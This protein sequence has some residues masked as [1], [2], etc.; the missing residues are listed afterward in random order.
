MPLENLDAR[1]LKRRLDRG[2]PITLLD[3][4]EPFERQLCAIPA[5]PT[6]IDLH[7]PMAEVPGRLGAIREAASLAPLVIYCHHGVRSA[8][9]GRWLEAQ[10]LVR[11]A[12]LDG[13]IDA[14]ALLADPETPRY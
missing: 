3:V 1:E 8:W 9:A 12:N 2:E 6:A 10:G 11:V 5:G 7:V 4:R 13:G 14:W